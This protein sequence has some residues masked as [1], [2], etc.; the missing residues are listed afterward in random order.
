[1]AVFFTSRGISRFTAWLD[2]GEVPTGLA[3][4]LTTDVPTWST[5]KLS[6]LDEIP[7]GNGYDALEVDPGQTFW[8]S[9][10]ESDA[11][12]ERYLERRLAEVAW[13]AAGGDIPDS[14]DGFQAVVMVDDVADPN[15]LCY[16]DLGRSRSVLNGTSLTIPGLALRFADGELPR[17]GFGGPVPT[18][19]KSAAQEIDGAGSGTRSPWVT[20]IAETPFEITHVVLGLTGRD[21]TELQLAKGP[22]G[23]EEIILTM[24]I[25]D[26]SGLG[27]GFYAFQAPNLN[28][29]SMP[30]S[31]PALERLSARVRGNTDTHASEEF[32]LSLLYGGEAS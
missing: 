4:H 3:L 6:E 10:T 30:L 16:I 32:Y 12:D 11:E 15:V 7:T 28:P 21:K 24:P 1:M 13:D 26:V 2:G 18:E 25:T 20:V 19:Y 23:S 29:L 9:E 22:S 31:V 5:K 14:G 8:S 27:L 17:L